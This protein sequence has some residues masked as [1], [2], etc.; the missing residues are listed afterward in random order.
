[1][2]IDN[3]KNTIFILYC[4]I[5]IIMIINLFFQLIKDKEKPPMKAACSN[6]SFNYQKSHDWIIQRFNIAA[7]STFN[8]NG[9]LYIKNLT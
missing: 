3:V 7:C 1:M 5:V 6:M 8:K 9:I 2:P 4:K